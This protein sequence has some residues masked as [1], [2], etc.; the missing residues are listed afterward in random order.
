[1]REPLLEILPRCRLARQLGSQAGFLRCVEPHHHG[2]LHHGDGLG[3]LSVGR[4]AMLLQS[5]EL[6][7]LVLVLRVVR[8]AVS[9]MELIGPDRPAQGAMELVIR[10]EIGDPG[11]QLLAFIQSQRPEPVQDHCH[12]QEQ[13]REETDRQHSLQPMPLAVWP[14][15]SGKPADDRPGEIAD[16]ER[17]EQDEQHP[18]QEAERKQKYGPD[19]QPL[20]RRVGEPPPAPLRRCGR[21][22]L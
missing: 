17:Q 4:L 21:T 18:P 8:A 10:I 11:Q 16:H 1:M 9:A 5:D 15:T 12:Y 20:P 19:R 3:E 22:G 13:R 6:L 2:V 7:E 14:K